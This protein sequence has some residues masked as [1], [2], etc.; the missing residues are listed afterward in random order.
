VWNAE[1]SPDGTRV[2]TASN[3]AT[4]R[5]WDAKTGAALATLKHELSVNSAKFSPDGTRVVTASQD[6][7]ARLWDAKTGAT[8]ATLEHGFYVTRATFSPDG[9][10]VVTA[11]ADK[12]A[13]LWDAKT[14]IALA[15]LR[16]HSDKVN[17]ARFS[18]DSAQVVTGSDD[19]TARIWQ[20]DP[21][22]LI[23]ADQSPSFVCRER[24]IGAQSFDDREMQQEPVLRGRDELRNPCDRVGPL[25]FDYYWRA[26]SSLVATV[27]NGS[28]PSMTV[29]GP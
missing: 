15:T 20:L 6:N 24:L 4:A 7:T 12:T 27:W 13:R 16:G 10:H 23:P 2:V 1:F 18:P 11:S 9:T 29:V 22:I 19:G 25:S 21:L 17:S 14:G 8:L 28:R 26:A 3:D 5:I